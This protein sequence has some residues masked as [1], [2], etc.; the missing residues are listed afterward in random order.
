MKR[1]LLAVLSLCILAGCAG[2]AGSGGDP[3]EQTGT[4]QT[5]FAAS[6]TTAE[7][8]SPQPADSMLEIVRNGLS[9]YVIVYDGS[10]ANAKSLALDV[11]GL[12]Y[13][14]TGALLK[15][16]NLSESGR[17][18]EREIIVGAARESVSG[19]VIG[20][21]A[22]NDFAVAVAGNSL[23]LW[24]SD[25]NM[26]GYLKSYLTHILIPV[27]SGTDF[28]LSKT[29]AIYYSAAKA[30]L[31]MDF[32][33][34]VDGG[35]SDYVI[36]YDSSNAILTDAVKAFSK[37][38]YSK[39]GITLRYKNAGSYS[40]E[41]EIV[42]GN[43]RNQAANVA[44]GL[45]ANNDFAIAVSGDDLILCATDDTAYLYLFEYLVNGV[46]ANLSED[47]WMMT[48][49]DQFIYS[50]SALRNTT[51][52]SYYQKLHGTYSMQVDYFAAN[53]FRAADQAKRALACATV[54]RLGNGFA[55]R[56]GS[57]V[58]LYQ[59]KIVRLDPADYEKTAVK[60]GKTVRIPAAFA[61]SYFGSGITVSDGYFDL[62][63]YCASS[64]NYTLYEDAAT[65]V[66]TVATAAMEPFGQGKA[67]NGY[68]DSDYFGMMSFFFNNPYRPEPRN[69]TEQ[70]R[71]VIDMNAAALDVEHTVDF[72]TASY[73]SFFDPTILN[74]KDDNGNTVLYSC[75]DAHVYVDGAYSRTDMILKESRDGGATWNQVASATGY[76]CPAMFENNGY[77]YIMSGFSNMQISRYDPKTGAFVSQTFADMNVGSGGVGTCLVKNGR[78]YKCYCGAV[79]SASLESNLLSKAS[80]TVSTPVSSLVT[81]SWRSSIGLTYTLNANPGYDWEEGS[82]VAG[83][84][85]KLYVVYRFNRRIGSAL[86]FELSA[87][88]STLSYVTACNGT[89]LAK[90][91]VIEIP[92]S[93]ARHAIHYDETTGKY[94]SLMSLYMGDSSTNYFFTDYLQRAVLGLVVSDDLVNWKVAD[95]LLV[96]RNMTDTMTSISSCGYQYVDYVIEGN[97]LLFVV[98]ENDGGG[99]VRYCH[100][101]PYCT[102]YR[103]S[104]YRS[105]IGN[106]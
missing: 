36:V 30:E 96:D 68:S 56:A 18:N 5:D 4:N 102:F 59:G 47:Y 28:A 14:A 23:V 57:S 74:V 63:A 31:G 9:D 39:L 62:T 103:I 97:D 49:K 54:E 93:I 26:Y 90:K 50:K 12:V 60:S 38:V 98:R 8:G 10:D 13:S 65:G 67:V 40:A 3:P 46:L 22:S 19:A 91:S 44:S 61:K 17:S 84:D 41:H 35:K 53:S 24:A 89:A 95:T 70:S 76:S 7:T 99:S 64:Q 29:T 33:T 104:D 87:D 69:N 83:K 106:P 15:T 45:A 79:V 82:V 6:A 88:G 72:N 92:S 52:V 16:Q 66:L 37:D 55:V 78:V 43:V 86:L 11:C 85:G 2:C 34:L 101:A 21:A 100:E 27:S 73:T 105:L 77:I 32:I 71:V 75:Y 58:A 20:R 42:V 51:Y 1:F 48:S 94:I 81:E 25:R 80:W